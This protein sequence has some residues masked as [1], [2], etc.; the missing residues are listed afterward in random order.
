M[1]GIAAVFVFVLPWVGALASTPSPVVVI[2]QTH[3][4]HTPLGM[5][6]VVGSLGVQGLGGLGFDLGPRFAV[7]G[8]L[9]YRDWRVRLSASGAASLSGGGVCYSGVVDWFGLPYEIRTT[10]RI[11]L[12]AGGGLSVCYPLAGGGAA[13]VQ[14][15]VEGAANLQFRVIP[16]VIADVTFTLGFPEGLGGAVGFALAY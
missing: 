4:F 13:M 8:Y 7:G 1:R 6:Q 5:D 9:E 16:N 15:S 2:N 11:R 12:G 3:V 14:P 10:Y